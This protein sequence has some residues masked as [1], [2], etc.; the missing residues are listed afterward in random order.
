MGVGVSI[1]RALSAGLGWIGVLGALA[2]M[3]G[4]FA[5]FSA[6][7][8]LFVPPRM[9]TTYPFA[10]AAPTWPPPRGFAFARGG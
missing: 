4:V 3:Y 1:R 6:V 7:P 10:Q 9:P 5:P 8:R 2:T